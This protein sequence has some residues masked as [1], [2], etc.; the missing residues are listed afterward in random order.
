MNQIQCTEQ[1]AELRKDLIHIFREIHQLKASVLSKKSSTDM[2][3]DS[4]PSQ[5]KLKTL[6]DSYPNNPNNPSNNPSNP[7]RSRTQEDYSDLPQNHFELE[8]LEFMKLTNPN[9]PNNPSNPNNPE[10]LYK[11]NNPSNPDSLYNPSS[12]NNP[13]IQQEYN[14]NPNNHLEIEALAFMELASPNNPSNPNTRVDEY[15]EYPQYI[16]RNRQELEH[17]RNK[18]LRVG[19]QYKT[20]HINSTTSG[21]SGDHMAVMSRL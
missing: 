17:L 9:N 12:P 4:D 21:H 10:H 14:D 2:D 7:H 5:S 8:A 19:E 20:D 16:E 15:P 1:Q 11:L 3:I 18:R 6:P 13:L